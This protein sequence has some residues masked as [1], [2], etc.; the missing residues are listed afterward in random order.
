MTTREEHHEERHL[1][2][3]ERR[4]QVAELAAAGHKP[5][6]IADMLGVHR[7]TVHADLRNPRV[8]EQIQVMRTA[9]LETLAD[10]ARE[11][12]GDAL[13]TLREAL[14]VDDAAIRVRS[15]QALLQALAPLMQQGDLNARMARL[16]EA[17][18][19]KPKGVTIPAETPDTEGD[20]DAG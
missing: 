5:G 7:S 2:T 10:T 1:K 16:E 14:T 12:A 8:V 9:C 4:I 6:A 17:A 20:T 19:L 15:A 18:G 11:A 13:K 3:G